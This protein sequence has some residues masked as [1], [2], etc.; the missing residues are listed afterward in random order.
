MEIPEVF[1][2]NICRGVFMR[3]KRNDIVIDMN[4]IKINGEVLDMGFQSRG[5]VFRTL[6]QAILTNGWE[7]AAI[8]SD[9]STLP[10]E[11]NFVYGYP[12][13]LPFPDNSFDAV[14]I[15]FSLAF[16]GRKYKRNRTIREI[17]RVLKPE[18]KLFI[19]DMDTSIMRWGFKIKIKAKLPGDEI[20]DLI[21]D[22]PDYFGN[23]SMKAILPVIER[24]FLVEQTCN[25]GKHYH[26]VA[27]KRMI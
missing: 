17:V 22:K 5:I 27:R 3:S 19:W 26:I 4:N 16:T 8:T 6:R 7:E 25:Y 13:D 23:H 24:Y 12:T 9:T 20:I 18:G 11:Y 14:T 21:I 10:D 15:F 1:S 2:I